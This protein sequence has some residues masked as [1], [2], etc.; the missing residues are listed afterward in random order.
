MLTDTHCHLSFKGFEE[1]YRAVTQRAVDAGMRLITIG[2]QLPTSEG[3]VAL[4]HEFS[5]VWA[6]V[7]VHPIHVARHEFPAERYAELARDPKVVA[8]GECGLDYFHLGQE[9][10]DPLEDDSV[11]S[12]GKSVDELKAMQADLFA[13]HLAL[14][15]AT[16]KPLILHCRDAYDDLLA[17]YDKLAPGHPGTL[18]CYTGD[19]TTAQ[20]YLERGLH[21]GFTGII[22]F[23]KSEATQEVVKKM[24]LDRL[25][26]ETDSPYLAPVPFRGKRNEPLY[27]E[28]VARKVAELRGISYEE[29]AEATNNNAARL[30]GLTSSD[31]KGTIPS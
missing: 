5:N 9:Y 30:F 28:H 26:L 14:A 6:A 25:L 31:G 18:H 11:G 27:V 10:H 22:T 12:G 29:V 2:T 3:A 23:P 21:I 13:K 17:L 16:N 7:A 20:K 8:I 1:D 19:W 24:P 4:A 15:K